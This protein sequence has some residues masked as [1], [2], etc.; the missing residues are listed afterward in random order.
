[1]WAAWAVV[2]NRSRFVS[3]RAL[4]FRRVT[5]RLLCPLSKL[6]LGYASNIVANQLGGVNGLAFSDWASVCPAQLHQK[7]HER[8]NRPARLPRHLWAKRH[9]AYNLHIGHGH[10]IFHFHATAAAGGG[11]C[12]ITSAG[13]NE[14]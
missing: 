6:G 10:F 3:N 1:V 12:S 5:T 13:T 14:K 11:T 8:I 9:A 2:I 4:P 7:R